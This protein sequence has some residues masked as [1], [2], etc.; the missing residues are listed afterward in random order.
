MKIHDYYVIIIT[1]EFISDGTVDIKDLG[2]IKK[3]LIKQI[4]E[5]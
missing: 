2:Q 4:S 5:F 3:Y 1:E